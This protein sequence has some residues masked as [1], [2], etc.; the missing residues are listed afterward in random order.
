MHS[1]T[2]VALKREEL[3]LLVRDVLGSQRS[4]RRVDELTEGMFNAAYALELEDGASVVLK[5]APPPELPLLTYERDLMRTEVEFYEH[6]AKEKVCPVPRVLAHDF[7]RT[8]IGRDFFFM[9]RLRGTPLTR[10]KN[11]LTTGE[12]AR[13]QTE[14]G[15]LV[16]RLR[17]IRGR[18]FGY[19]QPDTGLQAGTWRE[20]FLA[21]VAALLQDAER[22]AVKLPMPA[23]DVLALFQSGAKVLERVEEPTLTHF[24]LWE[25][26]VF[27]HR[28][29]G[30]ARIE[31]FIDGERAF[32]G[33]PLAELASTALFRDPEQETDFLR[34]YQAATGSPLVFTEEVRHR[35]NLYRAYLY[36]IMVLEGVPR[37]YSGLKA[38][39]IRQYCR[40]KLRGELKLLASR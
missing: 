1:R 12:R 7:S 26:N 3:A 10:A 9:E 2:K 19:L 6:A 40:M 25:G 31:A 36:L 39:A 38:M 20:A 27:V 21:M 28:V 14:L 4:V 22:F 8:R 24:D 37:G 15:E 16:G 5:V 29:E 18:F 32:W 17:T 30:A 33:D 11:Q 34:G 23:R 35:L 13:I